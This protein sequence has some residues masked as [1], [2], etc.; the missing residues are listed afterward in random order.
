[1]DARE[2]PRD[3]STQFHGFRDR[4]HLNGSTIEEELFIIVIYL[5][6]A[7]HQGTVTLMWSVSRGTTSSAE[8]RGF[9]CH[10]TAD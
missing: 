6:R 8:V 3:K 7:P 2:A 10:P 9:V 5:A 4:T 1:M